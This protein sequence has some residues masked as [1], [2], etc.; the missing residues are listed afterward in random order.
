MSEESIT[1]Q[2]SGLVRRAKTGRRNAAGLAGGY[3]GGTFVVARAAEAHDTQTRG[4]N[5]EFG[6]RLGQSVV[7]PDAHVRRTLFCAVLAAL[8][9]RLIVVGFVY[10]GFL[11]PG[12]DH[13]EFGYEIGRLAR[14]IAAGHGFANPYWADTGPT[15]LLTPVFPYLLRG[16]FAIFGVC[17]EASALAFLSLNCLFSALT[18]LPIF[19]VARMSFGVRTANWADWDRSLGERFLLKWRFFSLL[20]GLSPGSH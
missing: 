10:K 5:R 13:W 16:V 11:A 1:R 15:A 2:Q 18:C 4:L 9:V 6:L 17:K 8:G 14:S 20:S 19:F 12:R 7:A 3:S